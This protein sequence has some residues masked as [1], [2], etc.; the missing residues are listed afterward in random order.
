MAE[1]F[2]SFP[3]CC[4]KVLLEL[5]V[6]RKKGTRNC[7]AGHAVNLATALAVEERTRATKAGA[8]SAAAKK[9]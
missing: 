3:P 4:R 6:S 7:S 1:N 8:G 9:G 2:P 5:V